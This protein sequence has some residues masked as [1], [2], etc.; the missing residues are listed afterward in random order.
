[1]TVLELD[2]VGAH[3]GR[4]TVLEGITTPPIRGGEVVAVIGPNAAGK[5]TLLRRIAGLVDGAGVVRVTVDGD[6]TGRTAYMPQDSVAGAALSVYESMLLAVK[7]DRSWRVEK[8]VLAR[9]DAALAALGLEELAFRRLPELSGGQRQLVSLAQ[10]LGR[11]PDVMLLDE[12]TSALDLRHQCRVN[13]AVRAAARERGIVVLV[14]IHD[15][16]Q[17]LGIADRILVMREGRLA[18]F[19][20]ATDVVTREFMAEVYGVRVRIEAAHGRPNVVVLG[21]L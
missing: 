20:A 16:N 9:V 15:L 1:M 13:A 11:A 10:T 18:A 3:Y 12:P 6:R 14:S 5:S 8:A 21:S 19:G 2:A 7:R 17:A 4:R